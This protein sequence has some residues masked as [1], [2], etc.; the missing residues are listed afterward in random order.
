MHELI[1][2][3]FNGK[4]R[5]D[6]VI[7]SLLKLEEAYLLA[8]DDAVVVVKNAEGKIR[9][10]TYHDL[11]APVHELGNEL[12][13]GILSAV[14]FHRQLATDQPMF[15]ANFLTEVEASLTPNSSA[16]FV[17]VRYAETEQLL[18]TLA[19]AGGKIIKTA[20]PEAVL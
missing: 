17:I 8:L 16:L 5:A 2:V 20:L 1:I 10:K 18:A 13:G 12:W 4:F 6:E 14:V 7:L 19:S 3:S 15:D 9:V 11:V